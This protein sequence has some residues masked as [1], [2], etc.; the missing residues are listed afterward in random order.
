MRQIDPTDDND[1]AALAELMSESRPE[2]VTV[3]EVR[4]WMAGENPETVFC[5]VFHPDSRA[6]AD[7]YRQPWH[8]AGEFT[9]RVMVT[10]AERRRGLGTELLRHI[11]A[12]AADHGATLI[13]GRVREDDEAGVAFAERHG[14]TAR[15]RIFQSTLDPWTVPPQL[16]AEPDPPGTMIATF[17]DTPEHRRSLW[18]L[19]EETFLDEPGHATSQARDFEAFSAQV[20]DVNGFDPH[21][22][23]VARSGDLWTGIAM[24]RY[25]PTTNSLNNVYTG[26]D[27]GHRGRGIARALKRATIRFARDRG[28]A[29][30]WTSNDS[31]NAPMLAVN[32]HFG[33]RSRPALLDVA[34]TL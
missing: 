25:H 30:L 29:Y 14:Y 16:L 31:T 23:F 6:Y 7:V 15:R 32:R 3:A 20:F 33:Y 21:A 13:S 10:N 22:V 18:Q 34:L 24:L 5:G 11:T 27:S 1:L 17:T 4:S 8:P 26:V 19:F 28:A 12:F 2:P 9:S